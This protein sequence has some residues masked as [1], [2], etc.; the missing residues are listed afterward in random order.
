MISEQ[1]KT[2]R[3]SS[4]QLAHFGGRRRSISSSVKMTDF[5]IE[6]ILGP[7]IGFSKENHQDYNAKQQPIDQEESS[8]DKRQRLQDCNTSGIAID[9]RLQSPTITAHWPL[10]ERAQGLLSIQN[11]DTNFASIQQR[12]LD[13][14]QPSTSSCSTSL[15]SI[16]PASSDTNPSNVG[17]IQNEE[18]NMKTSLEAERTQTKVKRPRPKKF[19]CPHCWVA[20]SNSGQYRGHLRIHTGER[21]FKCD[22][23]SCSKTFTRNEELTRHKRIHTGQRPYGCDQCGKC[24]GRKDHLKKHCKTHEKQAKKLSFLQGQIYDMKELGK[25]AEALSF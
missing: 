21:P 23:P 20:L 12:F 5:S 10:L 11:G 24:F 22:I 2:E 15:D 18:Q 1:E 19:Q 16:S 8:L 13:P 4:S 7:R 3:N 6:A 9:L 17:L 14:S 25:M